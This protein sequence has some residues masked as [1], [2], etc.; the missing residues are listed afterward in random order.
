M[1][2]F[3]LFLFLFMNSIYFYKIKL[4]LFFINLFKL[5]K[6][7]L[8]MS[9][10]KEKKSSYTQMFYNGNNN[11]MAN[12]IGNYHTGIHS[13]KIKSG[14]ELESLVISDFKANNNQTTKILGKDNKITV[15]NFESLQ[16]PCLINS[17]RFSKEWY[18]QNGQTCKN[19]KSVE[20]DFVYIDENRNIHIIELK[21]GCNFDTKKSKG[22]VQS[23]TAT[24]EACLSSGFNGA[25]AY[26]VCYDAERKSD[27]ILKTE[28]GCVKLM[29]FEEMAAMM[30]IAPGSRGRI[31]RQKQIKAQKNIEKVMEFCKM[32]CEKYDF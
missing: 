31:N 22:E 21:N 12:D 16:V 2:L 29:L 10:K 28:L 32:M 23:L 20:I 5:L 13:D 7:L 9:S 1:H 11:K 14:N 6:T 4:I 8:K 24:R 3:I 26:I 27:M 17:C 15:D 25:E 30:S 18:E 19:K